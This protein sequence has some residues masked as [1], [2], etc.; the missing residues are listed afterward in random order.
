MN[1]RQWPV[2]GLASVCVGFGLGAD[3]LS[4]RGDQAQGVVRDGQNLP[5]TWNVVTGQN[6]AWKI[7]LPGRGLSAPIV[8]GDKVFVTSS[9]GY[10][11]DQLHITAYAAADGKELWRQ[12]LWATGRTQ[13]HEKTSVAANSPASDGKRIF[14]FFSSNDLACFDLDGRLLWA[15]ALMV[16]YP[17]ASNSLGM[18]GSL[19]VVDGVLVVPL[20]ND[21]ESLCL[22]VDPKT[23]ET[24]W[25]IDRPAFANWTSPGAYKPKGSDKSV[26]LLQSSEGLA[27][28][29]PQTGSLAWQF[30]E[31]CSTIPS[32]VSTDGLVLVPSK[33][34]TALRPKADGKPEVVWQDARHSPSTPSPVVYKDKVYTVARGGV[35]KAGKLADGQ[36]EWQVRLKG[37]FSGTPIAAD[38]KLYLFNEEGLGQVVDLKDGVANDARVAEYN[39]LNEEILCTPAIADGAIYVRSN[40]NLWKLAKTEKK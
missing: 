36:L 8:V 12:R 1:R 17:N 4:F 9:S 10:R 34:L 16:D 7:P 33:G 22:G 35:L 15:R 37:A 40:Q 24:K 32:S 23:G 20:E 29:D 30:E 25:K 21:S 2:L 6:I 19:L 11:Q 28:Y 27:A 14:V 39:D 13:C 38:D 26:V 31:G 3:W 5:E 18:A